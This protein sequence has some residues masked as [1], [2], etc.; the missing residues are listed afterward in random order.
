M[1][2]LC[3]SDSLDVPTPEMVSGGHLRRAVVCIGVDRA[4]KL[5]PLQA[6]AK[7]TRDFEKWKIQRVRPTQLTRKQ[8]V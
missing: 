2:E 8:G 4:G 5:R 7:G 6:A 3:R 1:C